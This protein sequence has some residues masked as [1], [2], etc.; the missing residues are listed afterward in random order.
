[1]SHYAMIE[2]EIRDEES[3]VAALKD[4][5]PGWEIERHTEPRNLY[6]Y[7][8]DMRP[9]RAHVIIRRQYVGGSS[10]DIGFVRQA[11]GTYGAIVSEFDSHRYD[12]K[13]LAKVSQYYGK[14]K[15]LKTAKANGRKATVH[16]RADGA[17][18]VEIEI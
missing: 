8:G 3:L 2:T 12:S 1:M 18:L 5:E 7:L 15:T 6:G 14:A 4:L 13:W 11:D 9:E 16:E 17:I 10:N